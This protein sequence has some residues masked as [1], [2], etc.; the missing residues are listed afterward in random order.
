MA[1]LCRRIRRKVLLVACFSV[2]LLVM[3]TAALRVRL[4]HG[5]TAP[6]TLVVLLLVCLGG[7][8]LYDTLFYLHRR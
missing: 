1:A 3:R 2:V 5:L 7:S 6:E 4:D 8:L